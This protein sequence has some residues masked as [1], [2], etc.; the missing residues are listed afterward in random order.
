MEDVKIITLNEESGIDTL[1]GSTEFFS[2]EEVKSFYLSLICDICI[3]NKK[4]EKLEELR[5]GKLDIKEIKKKLKNF[6]KKVVVVE[7][8]MYLKN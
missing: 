6:S 4:F 5:N 7:G 3:I 2:K 8:G 1:L